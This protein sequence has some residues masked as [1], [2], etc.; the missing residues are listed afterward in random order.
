MIKSVVRTN[1]LKVGLFLLALVSTGCAAHDVTSHWCR[2]GLTINGSEDEWPASFQYY[3]ADRQ[4]GIRMMNDADAVYICF[5]TND[6]ELKKKLLMTGLT[7]WLDPA[8]EKHKTFG[9]HL[10]GAGPRGLPRKSGADDR[11]GNKKESTTLKRPTAVDITYV[12]TTGPLSM[13][14]AQVRQTGIE[15][16]A[17]QPNGRRFV[18]EF[19]ICF[20]AGPS[21]SALGPGKTLGIGIETGK[22]DMNHE[23]GKPTE[24]GMGRTNHGGG[25][26]GGGRPGGDSPAKAMDEPFETWTKVTLA[27]GNVLQPMTKE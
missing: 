15:V 20:T 26:H 14:M 23:M 21:L 10:P 4:I 3:D 17:G 9:V 12:E 13:P 1:T 22:T 27:H 16:G 5:V 19:K 25:M 11:Q 24:G 7:V 6:K 18:Y 2:D 8:G